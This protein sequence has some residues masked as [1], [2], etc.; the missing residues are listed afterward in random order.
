MRLA[1]LGQVPVGAW[2]PFPGSTVDLASERSE[3]FADNLNSRIVEHYPQTVGVHARPDRK[4]LWISE[5]QLYPLGD[6]L[7]PNLVIWSE[8]PGARIIGT[9]FSL[10]T[11]PGVVTAVLIGDTNFSTRVAVAPVEFID[12]METL[13][14]SIHDPR[15]AR[16]DLYS[17][18]VSGG[19]ISVTVEKALNEAQYQGLKDRVMADPV[20]WVPIKFPPEERDMKP[21]K[22]GLPP[23][24]QATA[25]VQ[26]TGFQQERYPPL[27]R[28]S[29]LNV[30]GPLTQVAF[31]GVRGNLMIA[32][33]TRPLSGSADIVLG[34]VTGMRD[35]SGHQLISAPLATSGK[36]ADL[37]FRAVGTASVNGVSQTTMSSHLEPRL[38][39]L[40]TVLTLLGAILGI[41]VSLRR[42]RRENDDLSSP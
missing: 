26:R 30:F 40:G 10:G 11:K 25:R 24:V 19:T 22:F 31:R 15:G 35:E 28:Y 7:G 29:G 3:F 36:S 9:P 33:E 12:I 8:E 20:T 39:V 37:Q 2:V 5:P 21:G 17:Q 23:A 4:G 41:A 14:S 27:P 32:D 1:M 38:A 34:D 42:L 13:S 16:E 6:F 18:D